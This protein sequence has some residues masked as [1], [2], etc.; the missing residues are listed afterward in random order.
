MVRI[1][2]YFIIFFNS[3]TLKTR[4]LQLRA[5]CHAFLLCEHCVFHAGPNRLPSIE[6][7]YPRDANVKTSDDIT[8]SCFAGL[9]QRRDDNENDKEAIDLIS[10]STILHVRHTF[11]T[12]R[13]TIQFRVLW[14]TKTCNDEIK[15]L[16]LNLDMVLRNLASHADVLRLSLIHI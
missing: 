9:N 1:V 14:R 8:S 15:F 16:F 13:E 7:A 12:F 6:Y 11:C 2:L 4:D 5:V 3:E 10:K